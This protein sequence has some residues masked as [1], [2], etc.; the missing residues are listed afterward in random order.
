[1]ECHV[2][3]KEF[4]RKGHLTRH[5]TRHSKAKPFDCSFCGR[6]FSRRDSL[7]R[8]AALYGQ[9]SQSRSHQTPAEMTRRCQQACFECA[10][11]KQRCQG[12]TPCWR[13]INKG[14]FCSEWRQDPDAEARRGSDTSEPLAGECQ[15][16]D[17][18]CID[19][20]PYELATD[21]FGGLCA[22]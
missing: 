12:G 5:L 20:M 21:Q 17:N 4:K 9:D 15:G 3:G 22:I 18:L 10:R 14:L 2:C 16:E 19:D 6:Q 7:F 8:H 13:C 11:S 1:M